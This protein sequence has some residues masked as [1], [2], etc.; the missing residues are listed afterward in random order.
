MYH[1]YE[2]LNNICAVSILTFMV[3]FSTDLKEN[4][5]F[6]GCEYLNRKNQISLV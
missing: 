6:L 2:E 4:L 5:V 3:P 1:W